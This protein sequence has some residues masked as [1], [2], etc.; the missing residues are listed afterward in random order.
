MYDHENISASSIWRHHFPRHHILAACLI[1]L[2][3]TALLVILP[4]NV[5]ANRSQKLE[6]PA[7]PTRTE[8]AIFRTS[9]IN[10][11]ELG[12]LPELKATSAPQKITKIDPW[13]HLN[14]TA[15]DTLSTLLQAAGSSANEAHAIVT[16]S[17]K[18]KQLTQLAVDDRLDVLL[19][20]GKIQ[21][22]RLHRS[23]L[24]TVSV[25]RKGD[26]YDVKLVTR[27]P[28]LRRQFVSGSINSS[29]FLAAQ[30]A[31]L[32]DKMTLQLADIFAYDIDFIQNIQ[33]GDRF[34]VLYEAPYLDGEQVGCGTILAAEF[35][36]QGK[37][38][39]AVNYA[40]ASSTPR[41]Y[42]PD[43][44]SMRKQ[45]L[46]MPIDFARISSYFSGNRNH[47]IL[48]RIRA[49]KGIDY[50]APRGTPIKAAGDGTVVFAGVRNGYGN[51]V[52][53]Q[54]GS[55]YSTLYGHMSKINVRN[56]TRVEQGQTIGFVGMTGLATG[57][58]LHYEFHVNGVA[59]NPLANANMAMAEPLS[60]AE[61]ARFNR[62]TSPLLSQ[63]SQ[64]IAAATGR[65]Q[66]IQLAMATAPSINTAGKRAQTSKV[67]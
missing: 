50:A 62:L 42:T 8:N 67:R 30:Q 7:Q 41:Y 3:I 40:D 16:S 53:I 60:K 14:V 38:Y 47:P 22:L 21:E 32:S 34:S 11:S 26:N 55:A 61:K 1:S 51:V 12:F 64:H 57:P 29:L 9:P 33:S 37:T 35:S 48:N 39:S 45:F 4:D 24:E 58:H 27:T 63:M 25:T 44:K 66:N 65:P 43:G 49:H 10:T 23:K 20:D 6:S 15:G 17:E 59:K 54:H 18:A 28:E 46:R 31:G 19:D 36:N 56:G 13:K 52:M 5:A 2:L